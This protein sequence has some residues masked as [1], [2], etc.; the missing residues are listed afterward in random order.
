MS[1]SGIHA[2]RILLSALLL[3]LILVLGC[4]RPPALPEPTPLRLDSPQRRAVVLKTTTKQTIRVMSESIEQE[5]EED[6]RYTLDIDAADAS[7]DA[8]FQYT[9][10][11]FSLDMASDVLENAGGGMDP[12]TM[13]MRPMNEV[14]RAA[15]GLS[16]TGV[17]SPDGSVRSVDGLD[18]VRKEVLSRLA[19]RT[20]PP[21]FSGTVL[22]EDVVNAVF[23]DEGTREQLSQI[24]LER[25][26]EPLIEGHTWSGNTASPFGTVEL[27]ASVDFTVATVA[28]ESITVTEK[29]ALLKDDA[30]VQA[31]RK[32]IA[33]DSTIQIEISGNGSGTYHIDPDSGWVNTHTRS[34]VLNIVFRFEGGAMTISTH[35]SRNLET[36]RE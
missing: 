34:L 33:M 26:L 35:V 22:M 10:D 27:P 28:P 24:L 23:D 9:L 30:S 17:A 19:E 31:F 18:D 29:V 15:R 16:F 2:M 6:L 8:T 3:P 12:T 25:P 14:F 1:L 36:F 5:F 4:E 7:G 20:L 21:E 11:F 13:I 32:A